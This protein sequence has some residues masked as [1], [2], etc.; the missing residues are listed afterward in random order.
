MNY[1]W[2]VVVGSLGA[3]GF[4]WGTGANDV[5]NAFGTSVGAKTLTLP[6]A[7]IIAAIFEF[8][9]A[10]LLGRVSTETIA[11][12]IADAAVF[13]S[14]PYIYA[15]G[16]CCTLL[17]GFLWQAVASYKEWNVSSTH[18]IIGGIIGFALTYGGGSA[19]KWIVPDAKAFPP[20]KGVVPIV[21]SWFVSPV[22]TGAASASIFFLTRTFILRRY[23]S[24]KLSFWA[25]PIMTMVTTWINIYFVFTKGA[26]KMLQ[27]EDDWSDAKAAW[28]AALCAIGT[29][30]FATAAGIPWLRRR[31][32][33]PERQ[34][35]PEPSQ[36]ERKL[37]KMLDGLNVDIH[38]VIETDNVVAQIHG[39]AEIFDE[40]AERVF[41]YLQVFSA[42]C[43]IFAHGAGEVGYM[44]GPLATIWNISNEGRMPSSISAP[45]W[46]IIICAS[47]LVVGLSTYG[48]NITRAVGTKMAKLTPTRGFA[49][50]LATALV[51]LISAQYGLPTSSSQCITGAIVGIGLMEGVQ[52]VN[53]RLFATTFASW[54]CT[55]LVMGG[56]TAALFAQGIYAPHKQ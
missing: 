45:I 37:I 10:L 15:Y 22:L 27:T 40:K 54:I 38:E 52:G 56:G 7:T 1:L 49:A 47:G 8:A 6:Q 29:S 39:N 33:A 13:A 12:G 3:F 48:Y 4:G 21:L 50:E 26:K 51:I 36:T 2:L 46:V 24:Y 9:G 14:S 11:G 35:L 17:M 20:Y 18:S 55:M 42:I 53:W 30:V 5:G 16:M 34:P 44:S 31:I 41:S 32:E 19:V 25:I 28:I 23:N 43:V